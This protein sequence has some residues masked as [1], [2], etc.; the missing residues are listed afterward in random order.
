MDLI[1]GLPKTKKGHTTIVVFVDRLTKLLHFT[2]TCDKVTTCD[3][4]HIY[5][6]IIFKHHGLSRIFISDRDPHFTGHFWQTLF[7]LLGT[8]L[9][10]STIYHPQINGQIERVNRTF[11]EMLRA[12]VNVH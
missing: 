5:I 4:A 2:P 1:I 8:K 3:L 10:M 12:F 11:E 9:A 7:K 6:D